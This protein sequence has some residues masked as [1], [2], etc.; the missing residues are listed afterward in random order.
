MRITPT[1]DIDEALLTERFVRASGPGGQHVNK[2]ASAVQLRF[3]FRA[4]TTLADDVKQ[5]LAQLAGTRVNRRGHIVLTATRQR[6]QQRNRQD[7]RAR[8]AKLIRRALEPPTTRKPRR[9]PSAAAKR[10]RVDDK[11]RRGETK[12]QRRVPI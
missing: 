2:V 9:P 10:R 1:I 4:C 3:D 12:R 5:R 7:A 11:R 6:S 8:M